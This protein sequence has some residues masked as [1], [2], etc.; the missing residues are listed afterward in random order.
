[1]TVSTPGLTAAAFSNSGLGVTAGTT[2]TL[3]QRDATNVLNAT[4]STAVALGNLISNSTQLD[5]TGQVTG[6]NAT[7]YY[8]FNYQGN[9]PLTADFENLTGT[10]DLRV[11]LLNSAG[12]VI[13]D[14]GGTLAQ[15]IAYT[16]LTSSGLSANAGSYTVAVTYGP[17]SPKS[18]PQD[19]SL[20]LYSGNTF[21]GAYETTAATQT[22]AS[23]N[24]PVDNTLTFATSDAQLFTT[25]QY[26]KIDATAETAITIGWLYQNKTALQVDSQVTAA[27]QND[28]YTFTS[29]QGSALKLAFNNQTNTSDLRVQLLD[30]S[31]TDIIADSG[32]NPQQQAAYAALTSSSGLNAQPGQYVVKVSYAQGASTANSQTYQFS[33]YSGQSYSTLDQT[34]ASAET[35]GHA[36]LAGDLGTTAYSPQVAAATY[37][38]N[39]SQGVSQDA[40]SVL[41]QIGP[42]NNLPGVLSV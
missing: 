7:D 2:A 25:Q 18:L 32:G 29:E 39:Q 8:Q 6:Q 11:Q 40:L 20:S 14:S 41:E 42:Q 30:S 17:T 3:Y 12:T 38:F 5:A 33:V 34:T 4:P 16:Q 28:Y 22:S 19:Y 9:S 10:S 23:E 35:Y 21:Q 27:D 15:Q 26:N 31:G 24:V 37:L 1:M 36:V 13:A